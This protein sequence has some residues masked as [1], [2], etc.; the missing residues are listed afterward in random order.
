ME[1][2][3]F[4]G[5]ETAPP[6]VVKQAARDFAAVL[7]E[8]P[9]FA[10]FEQATYAFRHDQTAQKALQAYQQQQQS[11][12]AL[13][14]LNAL[15]VEQRDRL[16]HLQNEFNN[17]KVVQE[18]FRAQMELASLCQ[19]LGDALSESIGLSYAAACGVSCCG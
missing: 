12:R 4:E 3:K 15:S 16:E 1:D 8:T 18:Y 9:Q 10:A 11:L 7:S 19:E 2:L 6:S 13:M 5:I 17:L 14:M